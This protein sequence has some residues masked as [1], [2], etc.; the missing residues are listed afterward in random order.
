MTPL[1][2]QEKQ[3]VNSFRRIAPGR[4]RYVLLE[5]ARTAPDAWTRFREPAE[6]QLRDE[7][8]RRGLDWDQMTDDERQDFV[9][10]FMDD[11]GE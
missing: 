4:R 1:T 5:M 8:R 11:A 3:V 7:A 9:E 10:Q 6:T 2:P